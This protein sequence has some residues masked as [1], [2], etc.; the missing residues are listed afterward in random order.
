M[1]L[2][3]LGGRAVLLLLL[4]VVLL[5]VVGLLLL[6]GLVEGLVG[7]G[8]L[9]DCSIN[10]SNRPSVSPCR[11]WEVVGSYTN[12]LEDLERLSRSMRKWRN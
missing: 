5:G 12:A 6:L 2:L 7:E 4:D 10:S 9:H 11:G 1:L 3:V 8:V